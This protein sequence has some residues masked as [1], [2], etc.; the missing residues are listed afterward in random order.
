MYAAEKDPPLHFPFVRRNVIQK[1]VL[2]GGRVIS[3]MSNLFL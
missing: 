2:C 1:H 3:L